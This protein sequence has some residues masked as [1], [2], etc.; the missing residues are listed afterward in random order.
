[1]TITGWHVA[2]LVLPAVTFAI[3]LAFAR[4]EAAIL[5]GGDRERL[6]KVPAPEAAKIAKTFW[7]ADSRAATVIVLFY[8]I[9]ALDVVS[10][11]VSL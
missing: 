10:L 7:S 1:M 8:L 11:L 9:L 4:R 3:V 2:I 6:P 5:Y